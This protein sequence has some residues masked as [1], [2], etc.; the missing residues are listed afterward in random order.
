MSHPEQQRFIALVSEHLLKHARPGK[1]LE[2]GSYDV[3]GINRVHFHDTPSYLGVDLI[4][5]PGVDMVKSG[6]ELDLASGSFDLTFSCE[7]FEHNPYW[8]ETLLNMIRMTKPGGLVVFTCASLGRLEHGTARV[9]GPLSP[10]T[11]LQGWDYY[12]NLRRRDFERRINLGNHFTIFRFYYLRNCADLYFFGFKK[13]G[14]QPPFDLAAFERQVASIPS[15]ESERHKQRGMV[16]RIVRR[17]HK[18]P[19]RIVPLIVGE[20]WFQEF[21]LIYKR[22]S[23][24]GMRLVGWKGL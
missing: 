6:H 14:E 9:A 2:I 5:G 8:L 15:M 18:I 11:H 17:M 24:K 22:L 7:C 4:E 20:K 3:N 16:K 10:G 23:I 1:V 19:L 12:R 21:A 13:G